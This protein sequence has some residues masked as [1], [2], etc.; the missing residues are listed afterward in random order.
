MFETNNLEKQFFLEKGYLVKKNILNKNLNFKEIS[1][2]FKNE[3]EKLFD[4]KHLKYLGGYK[5]GN[6]NIYPGKFGEEILSILNN[7]S[8][9]EY[10][11]YLID[12]NIEKYKIILGGNLNLPKSKNQFF[13]TDGKWEPRMIIVNIATSNIE[14]LNGPLEIIEKTHLNK[15]SYW[16]FALRIIFMK[17]KKITLGFGDILIREHRLWHRGTTNFSGNNRE[18]I[19]IMFI[20]SQN[21]LEKLIDKNIYI[22]PNIFGNTLKEKLKEYLFLYFRPILFLYKFF[23]SMIK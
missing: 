4:I 1:Q 14:L 20:K 10:L 7:Y 2:N 12:D 3:L 11:N 23:I 21:N 18:M 13:H 8:F 15:I 22:K 19:G 6:L 17:K 5:S 16:R 9:K